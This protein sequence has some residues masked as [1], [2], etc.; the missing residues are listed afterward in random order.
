MPRR[1]ATV[2]AACAL[3]A[4]VSL[5]CSKKERA[6][7]GPAPAAPT[8]GSVV[9]QVTGV[10]ANGTPPLGDEV[11][12]KVKAAAVAAGL[13]EAIAEPVWRTLVERCI[14]YEFEAFDRL[15]R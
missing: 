12:A 9:L 2:V 13:S 3:A 1:P 10:E 6:A 11:V 7:P 5:S 15:R 4:L 14:A 8:P